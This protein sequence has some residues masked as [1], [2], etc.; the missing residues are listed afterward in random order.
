MAKI[1]DGEIMSIWDPKKK[2][3]EGPNIMNLF[4]D[5]IFWGLLVS[6]GVI[7]AVIAQ[8][9]NA[10]IKRKNIMLEENMDKNCF[11]VRKTKLS[12]LKGL[13]AAFLGVAMVVFMLVPR[14]EGNPADTIV[15]TLASILFGLFAL[16][17]VCGALNYKYWKVRVQRKEIHCRALLESK[18]YTFDMIQK[19]E[20]Y[21]VSDTFGRVGKQKLR[22]YFGDK[23]PLLMH[24]TYTGYNVFANR[25]KQEG[26]EI[27]QKKG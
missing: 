5:V 6:A 10:K 8:V 17:G 7:A 4:Q 2:Y 15:V 12:L 19:A 26:I 20:A 9:A 21:E 11:V 23:Y 1:E 24:S 16:G 13:G 25:L 3:K 14:A 27:I 18:T 22:L